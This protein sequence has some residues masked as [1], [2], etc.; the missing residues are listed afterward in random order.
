MLT[1][2]SYDHLHIIFKVINS[3]FQIFGIIN[4]LLTFTY[5]AVDVFTFL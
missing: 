1:T 2:I 4:N 5:V 3:H